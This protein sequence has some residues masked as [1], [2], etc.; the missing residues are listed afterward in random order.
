MSSLQQK[1]EI[2]SLYSLLFEDV[3]RCSSFFHQIVTFKLREKVIS[4]LI[5]LLYV[6]N[7]SEFVV[8]MEDVPSSIFFFFLLQANLAYPI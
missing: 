4:L 8:W 1:C 3:C 2:M 7:I 6:L 5:V